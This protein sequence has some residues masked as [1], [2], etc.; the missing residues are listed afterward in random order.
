MSREFPDFIDPWRAA[1][2]ER[3]IAGTMPLARLK[4]L[5]PLLAVADGDAVAGEASF[6]LQF[7]YDAQRRASVEVEVAAELPLMCQRS[8]KPYMESVAQHSVLQIIAEA[9]EQQLLSDEEEFVLVEE[10]RLAVADLVEDELLLAV[11]QVPRNPE[12]GEV[13]SSTTAGDEV[14]NQGGLDAG[15]EASA[16]EPGGKRQRPF[17]GLAEMMK[18]K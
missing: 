6:S 9:S 1:D 7:G 15:R 14:G 5:V 4:R 12:V 3:Q 8:L 11:P 13:L 17:A 10:G 18:Q 16:E 2:G